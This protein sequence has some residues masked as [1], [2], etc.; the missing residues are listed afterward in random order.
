MADR[1]GV[2][3]AGIMTTKFVSAAEMMARVLGA[4]DYSFVV[5]DH[6]ISSVSAEELG[7]RAEVAV[8]NS[9]KILVGSK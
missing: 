4:E 1:S 8:A 7:R 2:P 5:V 9:V 6:P 3:A